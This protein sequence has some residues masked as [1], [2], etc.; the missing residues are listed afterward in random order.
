MPIRHLLKQVEIFKQ[1]RANRDVRPDW[2]TRFIDEVA[3]LFDPMTEVGRVGFD[4]RMDEDCWLVGLFL[5]STEIIGGPD[6]G[7]SHYTN[8][9]FDLMGLLDKFS[10]IERLDW[11]SLP[12]PEQTEDPNLGSYVTIDGHID[13]NRL[14]LDIRSI[15]PETAGPGFKV[16]PDGRCDIA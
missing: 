12:H 2:V 11:H 4:C 10:S 9:Q 13:Q 6:D 3:D 7:Q 5:G 8:F 14:R 16:Y 1:T 15:P